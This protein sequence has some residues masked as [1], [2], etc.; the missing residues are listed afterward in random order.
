[1]LGTKT[2]PIVTMFYGALFESYS[3]CVLIL[4]RGALPTAKLN[5]IILL[6]IF[7]KFRYENIRY[8]NV[9][10]SNVVL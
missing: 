10:R 5:L 8:E 1:M 7:T 6:K 4:F 2:F 9:A 3:K